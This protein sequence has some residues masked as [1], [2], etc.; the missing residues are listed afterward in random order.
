[1]CPYRKEWLC[2][3]R[4]IFKSLQNKVVKT[5]NFTQILIMI[6]QRSDGCKIEW[7][8]RFETILLFSKTHAQ[9]ST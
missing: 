6:I 1:M 5:R 9:N 4:F 2:F 8:L 7:I 3:L